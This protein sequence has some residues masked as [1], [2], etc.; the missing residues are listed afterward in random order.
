MI[1]GSNVVYYAMITV[2]WLLHKTS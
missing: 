2:L 1:Q